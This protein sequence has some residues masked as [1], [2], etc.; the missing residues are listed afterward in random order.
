MTCSP[1]QEFN[2]CAD[3]AE[4]GVKKLEKLHPLSFRVNAKEKARIRSFAER[5]KMSVS[6]Y[7]RFT[8]LNGEVE[9]S[10]TPSTRPDPAFRI[11]MAAR[12]LGALGSSGV[13]SN[14]SA[15]ANAAEGGAL[16]MT[17]SLEAEL[18]EACALVVAIRRDLIE[19]LGIKAQ[20]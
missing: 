2:R 3:L 10:Q 20:S 4:A 18:R 15:L 1:I 17:E 7:V 8:A 14:L 11:E 12:V 9:T 5:H 16:P 13:L 6:Q 19:A